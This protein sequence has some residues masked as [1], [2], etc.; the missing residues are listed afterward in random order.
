LDTGCV[1]ELNKKGELGLELGELGLELGELALE[2][3][4]LGLELGELD[5]L[6]LDLGE[7]DELGELVLKLELAELGFSQLV[8]L[9][10]LFFHSKWNKLPVFISIWDG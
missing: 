6:V 9:Q 3:G 7:L 10:A 8:Q 4:E 2:L 1:L 5:E